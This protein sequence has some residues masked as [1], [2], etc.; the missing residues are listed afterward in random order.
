[1][2]ALLAAYLAGKLGGTTLWGAGLYVA[3]RAV[4]VPLYAAGVPIVRSMVWGV[5][6]VGLLMVT[7]A[8]FL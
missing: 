1:A 5:S 4:Y 3:G 6:M 7:A 2:A 8:I